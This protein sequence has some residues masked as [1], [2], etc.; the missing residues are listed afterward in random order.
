MRLPS[1][2]PDTKDLVQ[3]MSLPVDEPDFMVVSGDDYLRPMDLDLSGNPSSYPPTAS[4]FGF[5]KSVCS[6]F[7]LKSIQETIIRFHKHYV[8]PCHLLYKDTVVVVA[9]GVASDDGD[10]SNR[11]QSW[12]FEIVPSRIWD[13]G[14]WG[15]RRRWGLHEI[16]LCPIMYN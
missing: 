16:L 14:R 3:L 9:V 13:G 4:P 7:T 10:R 5:L 15:R 2:V 12:G 6:H 1:S 11:H 8:V